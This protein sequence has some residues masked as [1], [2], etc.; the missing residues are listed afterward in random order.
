MPNTELIIGDNR[1]A[2]PKFKDSDIDCVVT[3]PP[4]WGLRDYGHDDQI[5][6]EST[7]DEFLANLW[8]VFDLIK[9]K[10]KDTGNCFVNI[11]DT[12]SNTSGHGSDR[13]VPDVPA[14][15]MCMIPER[16]AWGMI[17][18][19]WILRNKIIWYKP[20]HMPESVTDRLT[21]SYEFMYHF[22]KSQTYYYDL[23]SIRIPIKPESVERLQRAVSGEHKYAN[24]VECGAGGGLNDARP[25]IKHDI[26]VSRLGSYDD[27][28]HRRAYHPNGKNPGD[29]WQINTA[30]YKKA[31][32]ATFPLELVRIPIIAGCP[33]H[34][35][36]VDPFGGSGTVAEFCRKNN[37]RC[38][39]I[40]LNQEY[41][42][43]IKEKSMMN[44]PSLD[45]W[46]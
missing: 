44:I 33:E 31:H 41:E 12:Y 37:R 2:L 15:C 46:G 24:A 45:T 42:G 30:Q 20:N 32:F 13:C 36:V 27:P 34:G 28:L 5:G 43:L 35:H 14:K 23:D 10:L 1:E 40:E 7:P 18:R 4:Y 26:A 8:H 16:F 11:A 6:L 3:S 29:M 39:I 19:G 38:T 9:P 25:N 22:T 21:K 17:E